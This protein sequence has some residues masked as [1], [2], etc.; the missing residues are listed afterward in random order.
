MLIKTPGK[1]AAPFDLMKLLS[2]LNIST[3]LTYP[4]PPQSLLSLAKTLSQRGIENAFSPWQNT[5]QM[6]KI[7]PLAA[8]DYARFHQDFMAWINQ[9]A[10][11]FINSAELMRWNSHK[12][13]L[14]DLQNLGINVIPT[15]ICP[16]S[17]SEISAI[18]PAV[19]AQQKREIVL[20]PAVG[21][22]GNLV[23]KLTQ[24]DDLPDL[25]AY[26]KEVIV[27]PFIPEVASVGETSLVFFNGQFSHAICRLPAKN[28]WRA[29]SQYGV[30]ILP[31][32]VSDNIIQQAQNAL[33][34]LPEMPVY[35]RVDGTIINDNF[36]LNELELIEPA[37]YL[38]YADGAALRFAQI[39]SEQLRL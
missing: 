29:N 22:S 18:L 28:E 17:A 21:Q 5:P 4:N 25:T 6:G 37:L 33:Q 3:C 9:N 23:C 15:Q 11:R 26:G 39:L 12:R 2:M 36:L 16:T 30:Q 10:T 13:Y 34:T 31:C 35:A 1:I 38:D 7:L 24:F 32:K 19:L 8:W 14:I 27:Q 20:K